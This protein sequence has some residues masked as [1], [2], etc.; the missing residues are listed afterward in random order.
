MSSS[1]AN[2]ENETKWFC[3]FHEFTQFLNFWNFIVLPHLHCLFLYQPCFCRAWFH[4][5]CA[6]QG[7]RSA[8]PPISALRVT[9]HQW[10]RVISFRA[11]SRR[12]ERDAASAAHCCRLSVAVCTGENGAPLPR[13]NSAVSGTPGDPEMAVRSTT[14]PAASLF[15]F[16]LLLFFFYVS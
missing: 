2:G 15:S 12:T 13:C 3:A 1:T 9:S 6:S 8:P 16:F 11:R 7:R 14:F 4:P 10:Q 5:N